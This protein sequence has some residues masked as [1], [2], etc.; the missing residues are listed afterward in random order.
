MRKNSTGGNAAQTTEM[1]WLQRLPHKSAQAWRPRIALRAV[2]SRARQHN[3]T[4]QA[5]QDLRAWS[6]WALRCRLE[7]FKR[8]AVTIKNRFD[9]GVRGMLNHR[10]NAFVEPMK[11]RPQQIKSTARGYGTT[12][13]FIAIAYLH[14]SRLENLPAHPF[15]AAARA[16]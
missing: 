12:R 15:A 3:D 2:Y 9:A 11:G 8:L 1:H 16:K 6:N 13:N 14:L 10:S 4:E 7:S 5:M